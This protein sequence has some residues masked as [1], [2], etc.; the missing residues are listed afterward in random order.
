MAKKEKSARKKLKMQVISR[1]E[2]SFS[3]LEGS[4][5]KTRFK[6]NIKKAAK[7]LM[8]D[9]KQTAPKPAKQAKK[10]TPAKKP[11]VVAPEISE[12]A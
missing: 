11:K 9:L 7:A 2:S 1:L 3:D 4:L 12:I 8:Q 6:K 5:G 10:P